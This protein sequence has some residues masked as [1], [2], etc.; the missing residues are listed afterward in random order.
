MKS[1]I[2]LTIGYEGKSIDEFIDRLHQ[3]NITRLIDVREIPYSRKKGFSKPSLQEKL[4]NANIEYVHL[5]SLGSPL[6][7]RNRLRKHRDYDYFFK[8]YS[9]YLSSQIS[10]IDILHKY[11]LDGTNCIMCF[12]RLS[13]DCHRSILANKLKEYDGNGLIIKHV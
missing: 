6:W 13:I 7:L 11:L 9:T 1:P 8:A 4:E 10:T 2:L 3:F 12:E 5:K